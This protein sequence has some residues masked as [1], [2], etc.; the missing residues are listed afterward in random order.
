MPWASQMSKIWRCVFRYGPASL[1]GRTL[2]LIRR[3]YYKNRREV[4]VPLRIGGS[5]WVNRFETTNVYIW[6]F[7]V[8][9]PGIT[10]V[11][12]QL[13]RCGEVFVDIGS[14][15]GY[16]SILASRA[17]ATPIAVEP[18]PQLVPRLR[19]NLALNGISCKVLE[20]AISDRK[21][22]ATFYGGQ[23][24]NT[25]KGSLLEGWTKH[26][27]SF[28]VKVDTLDCLGDQLDQVGMIKIDVE[29][30]EKVILQQI[31]ERLDRATK[32]DTIIFEL[33]P[34]Q[35]DSCR[36]LLEEFV[37]HDFRIYMVENDYHAKF[38]R[39]K[40]FI[41][42]EVKAANLDSKGLSTDFILSKRDF[43]SIFPGGVVA[44][45]DENW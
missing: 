9:E 18:S 8:W 36:S 13:I 37:A 45:F 40:T 35:V 38:Y 5:M 32:L 23:N 31:L 39:R 2:W 1:T 26:F 30:V 34:K 12:R 25:G 41:V 24:A 14:H 19:R 16:F 29:G 15:L 44:L 17:G 10:A 6:A 4:M 21:G 28:K 42:S 20:V 11:M 43:D 3:M 22:V 7:G 27:E 33:H